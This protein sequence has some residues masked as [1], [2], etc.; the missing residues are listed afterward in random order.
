[1]RRRISGSRV[2]R[3]MLDATADNRAM[4][5]NKEPPAVIFL[6]RELRLARPPTVFA[7]NRY[8]PFRDGVFD[9]VIYDPLHLYRYGK[10]AP[11]E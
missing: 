7:D 3:L 10:R 11:M 4:W 6:D 9:C 5:R 2:N 8:C 1:M